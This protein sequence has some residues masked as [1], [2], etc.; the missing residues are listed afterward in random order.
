M[1]MKEQKII[2]NM[3]W[4]FKTLTRSRN[5]AERAVIKHQIKMLQHT[6]EVIR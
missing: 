1:N 2:E 6:L 3:A 5:E 4:L